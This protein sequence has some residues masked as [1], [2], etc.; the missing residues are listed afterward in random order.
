M[1]KLEVRSKIDRYLKEHNI[2]NRL[3]NDH[4]K[5]MRTKDLDTFYLFYNINAPG[6][7]ES[8]IRLCNEKIYV[9]AYYSELVAEE[10]KKSNYRDDLLKVI[11]FINANV[12]FESLYTPRLYLSTD[13]YFNIAITTVIPYDFFELAPIET[14]EYITAYYPEYMEK[15]L[16]PIYSVTSG[17]LTVGQVI[18]YIKT[19]ILG[20]EDAVIEWEGDD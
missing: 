6:G 5:P 11:N 9:R 15:F 18:Y 10:C 7:I 13:S 17:K 8:D 1:N 4:N 20:D 19:K 2:N 3:I 16:F 12:F 14:M